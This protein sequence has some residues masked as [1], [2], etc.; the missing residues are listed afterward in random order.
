MKKTMKALVKKKAQE[1]IW[2]DEVA[3]PEIA[4]PPLSDSGTAAF[5]VK[6]LA[7]TARDALVTVFVPAVRVLVMAPAWALHARR[8]LGVQAP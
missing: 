5:K 7:G 6:N 3:V 2:L 4:I 1:G 8:L